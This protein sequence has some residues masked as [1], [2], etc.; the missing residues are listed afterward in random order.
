MEGPVHF[1]STHYCV[2]DAHIIECIS[3][4]FPE[5]QM[6]SFIDN[7]SFDYTDY[8]V[9]MTWFGCYHIRLNC[10]HKRVDSSRL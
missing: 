10:S 9:K 6:S 1:S 3:S 5:L 8:G 4:V 2:Q 7:W